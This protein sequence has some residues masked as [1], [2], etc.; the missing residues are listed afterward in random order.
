MRE[1]TRVTS[2]DMMVVQE[3]AGYGCNPHFGFRS[4]LSPFFGENQKNLI[5]LV[6]REELDLFHN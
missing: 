2:V 6:L 3:E 1:A 5:D 4:L